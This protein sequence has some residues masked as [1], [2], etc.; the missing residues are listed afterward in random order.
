MRRFSLA[1]LCAPLAV[2][3]LALA[4]YLGPRTGMGGDVTFNIVFGAVWTLAFVWGLGLQALPLRDSLLWG[5]A[6]G[7][8]GWLIG[9]VTVGGILSGHGVFWSLPEFR[10]LFPDL[11]AYVLYGMALGLIYP[12]V[13]R[14]YLLRQPL[15]LATGTRSALIRG[16]FAGLLTGLVLI[17]RLPAIGLLPVPGMNPNDVP[18]AIHL[19]LS[20]LVGMVLGIVSLQA[21]ERSGVGLIRGMAYGLLWWVLFV[22]TVQPVLS[23]QPPAWTFSGA[24]ATIDRLLGLIVYGGGLALFYHLITQ[25]QQALFADNVGLDGRE[26]GIGI[27]NLQAI[28]WGVAGSILGGLVFTTVM[29][30]TGVLP[31]IAGIVRG[32]DPT[33]GL[34][35]HFVISIIIGAMYGLLFAGQVKSFGSAIGW[36][37]AYG[38]F[39]WVLGP[40]TFL[41]LLLGRAGTLSLDAA[42]A[43]YPGSFLGHIAYGV[44][45]A[46]YFYFLE[47]RQQQ[48]RPLPDSSKPLETPT[49]NTVQSPL[50]LLMALFIVI[51]PLVLNP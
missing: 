38:L 43:A 30:Q 50:W 6:Y 26:E 44:V 10:E 25:L 33:I 47:R 24:Q 34:I 4:L 29:V 15:A 39:W 1:L 28:G 18:A 12:S 7:F 5:S 2:I 31:T 22:L 9:P 19:I 17:N 42:L 51:V 11:I 21:Q 8:L 40:I 49:A 32:A 20:V 41:P 36:G 37:T 46:M 14:L 16:A 23:N 45:T 35:V 27:R 48:N 13:H 3:V